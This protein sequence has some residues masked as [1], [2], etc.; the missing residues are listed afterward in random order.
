M[1][2]E[3][4]QELAERLA[5]ATG[6]DRNLDTLLWRHLAG[7]RQLRRLLGEAEGDPKN[8]TITNYGHGDFT[9]QPRNAPKQRPYVV[10]RYTSSI[11]AALKV[12]EALG[13]QIASIEWNKSWSGAKAVE[14]TIIEGEGEEESWEAEAATPSLAIFSALTSA[15][16]AKHTQEASPDLDEDDQGLGASG[17]RM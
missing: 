11:D 13:Y 16:I 15:L 3:K 9:V 5:R 1:D 6:P 10:P 8:W 17:P 7:D 12:A 4:L 2:I 14:V